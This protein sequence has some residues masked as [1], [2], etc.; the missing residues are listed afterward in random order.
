MELKSSPLFALALPLSCRFWPGDFGRVS[1]DA[2]WAISLRS[3]G[4]L[5]DDIRCVST[6]ASWDDP[7]E[8]RTPPTVRWR[9]ERQ[10]AVGELRDCEIS[11]GSRAG[12]PPARRLSARVDSKSSGD[13]R[14]P[15]TSGAP[16]REPG[17]PS[18]DPLASPCR[19]PVIRTPPGR[20]RDMSHPRSVCVLLEKTGVNRNSTKSGGSIRA[21]AQVI[22]CRPFSRGM[23]PV[24]GSRRPVRSPR[25]AQRLRETPRFNES[26]GSGAGRPER[27]S[28]LGERTRARRVPRRPLRP[29]C[30]S[31]GEMPGALG[32]WA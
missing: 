13:E 17:P 26:F 4:C 19:P 5:L 7:A 25:A 27:A 23:G 11:V 20:Q 30:A 24:T 14:G 3:N 1:T 16:E 12:A 9:R 2:R 8:N 22:E 15:G 28:W 29:S 18:R 21:I 6:D 32:P 10:E 31:M